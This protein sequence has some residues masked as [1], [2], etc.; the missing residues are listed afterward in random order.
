DYLTP[1]ACAAFCSTVDGATYVGVQ[2]GYKCFCGDSFGRHGE[3]TLCS[4]SCYGDADQVCGAKNVNSVYTLLPEDDVDYS[5]LDATRKDQEPVCSGGRCGCFVNGSLGRPLLK[6]G[7]DSNSGSLSRETCR[8]ACVTDGFPFFGLEWSIFC[9]CG[10]RGIT[11]AEFIE[12]VKDFQ[13]AD[14]TDECNMPCPGNKED[15]CGGPGAI[16]IWEV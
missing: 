11:K 7:K 10:G 3:S 4:D 5:P 1:A 15:N 14:D 12:G 16:E 6:G 9:H 2:Y 8:D 13:L